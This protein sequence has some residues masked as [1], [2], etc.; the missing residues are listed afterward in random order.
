LTAGGERLDAR[1]IGLAVFAM[2]ILGG[3]YTVGKV[4]LQDLPVFGVLLVRMAVTVLALGAYAYF[5]GLPLKPRRSATGY[6]VAQTGLYV[7]T[8]SLLFTA[9]MMTSAG[10]AA[11][12]FNMQPF[13]T[14]LL[15]PLLLPSERLT[16]LRWLGTAVAF[17]GVALV[18]AERG[19]S[20]GSLLGDFMVLVAAL[21]WTGAIILN[22][23][24]PGDISSV[25]V[26]FWTSAGAIPVYGL[27]TLLFEQGEAWHLTVSA[28]LSVLYLG[29][30]A[31][32]FG[33][34]LVV[35]LTR[36]YSASRVNVFVFLS[37]V[38]G[39]LIGWVALGETVS[40]M[41]ALGALAVAG[42]ILIVTAEK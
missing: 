11:I 33:F 22:K 17:G 35:W 10:R 7:L 14:L 34:V 15:L 8:Q 3:S 42:G 13:F 20:G 2:A 31:A 29:V 24:M 6:L 38:F 5:A 41:Q 40:A 1:A 32:C 36:T 12:L 9:L 30:V 23:R 21:G 27:L 26:I 37:P 25:S 18:L 4:A 28:A 16:R 19:T 39:V